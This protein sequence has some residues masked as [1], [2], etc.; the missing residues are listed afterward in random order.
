M[1]FKIAMLLEFSHFT[2]PPFYFLRAK[3]ILCS[4]KLMDA[5]WIQAFIA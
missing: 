5:I 1:N 3:R 2:S 4:S